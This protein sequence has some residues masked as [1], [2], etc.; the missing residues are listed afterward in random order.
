M[1]T[2]LQTEEDCHEFTDSEYSTNIPVL[3]NLSDNL[4]NS[5][6]RQLTTVHHDVNAVLPACCS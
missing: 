6:D 2:S 5:G 4:L 1:K 3:L